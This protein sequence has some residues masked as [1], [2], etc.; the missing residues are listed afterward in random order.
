MNKVLWAA[1]LA[2]VWGGLVNRFILK[3]LRKLHLGQQVYEL[4]PES[5]QKKQG[6]PT[7]GGIMF[8]LAMLVSLLLMQVWG[9]KGA[10]N[11]LAMLLMGISHALL[12]FADD[13][14][15]ILKK[16]NQGLTPKQKL[17]VQVVIALAFSIYCWT[18]SDVGSRIFVPFLKR[19][20]D[21][22]ILY[23]PLMVF[24]VVGTTNSANLL[25]GLDGLLS[26]VSM[27]CF[28]VMTYLCACAGQEALATG[29][30][31]LTGGIMAFLLY[32]GYPARTF[33]GDTGSMFIGGALCSCALMIRQ[34]VVLVFV[35]FWMM[36]SSLS[37]LIQFAYFR[38]TKGKRI[39]KMAP[40][41]HH[42]E[43]SGMHE[44][45]IVTMY[46][47]TTMALSILVLL[48]IQ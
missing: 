26:S 29:C 19:E 23:I 17:A 32:N 44:Q 47:V 18:S 2:F 13:M 11:L 31:A 36:M 41:H 25:D 5:H 42:F 6:T 46:M 38:A 22:G 40:I 1:L 12:G 24:I 28:G 43:L 10:G 7:M 14:T 21:L 4:A 37:D 30:A 3:F 48:G 27:V 8:I 16:Q 15:K 9:Q 35:G 34:P 33:M 20:V 39:F 45:H